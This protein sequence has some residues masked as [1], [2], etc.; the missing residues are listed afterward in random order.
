LHWP[1][2]TQAGREQIRFGERRDIS[3]SRDQNIVLVFQHLAETL[4]CNVKRLVARYAA[5]SRRYRLI[6]RGNHDP[7]PL[8]CLQG[9]VAMSD[10]PPL[11]ADAPGG[12]TAPS[13]AGPPS[14]DL[15]AARAAA[16]PAV[17]GCAPTCTFM[18]LVVII[19]R[20]CL[21]RC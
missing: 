18:I 5:R 21:D 15:A 6:R 13:S 20:C 8:L 19:G 10:V 16:L 3:R 12:S 1:F 17:A 9:D 4:Y 11:V 2:R 14:G 7:D